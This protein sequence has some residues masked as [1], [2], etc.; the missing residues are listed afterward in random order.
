MG[1]NKAKAASR[2][3][4]PNVEVANEA[5]GESEPNTKTEAV[6]VEE[7]EKISAVT[8]T[9]LGETATFNISILNS[10]ESK[11]KVTSDNENFDY[12]KKSKEEEVNE[13]LVDSEVSKSSDAEILINND[14]N[15]IPENDVFAQSDDSVETNSERNA[16]TAP[17]DEEP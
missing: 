10:N 6:D 16:E 2:E 3:K 15:D 9:E 14:I 1:K 11:E 4:V 5:E 13:V 8:S 12:P 17:I 7:L